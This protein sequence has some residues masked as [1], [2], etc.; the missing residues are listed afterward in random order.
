MEGVASPAP[1]PPSAQSGREGRWR[2]RRWAVG[3]ALATLVQADG[4]RAVRARP[5][6]RCTRGA[7]ERRGPVT[8]PSPWVAASMRA[9]TER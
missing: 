1:A 4:R 5:A 2:A 9:R 6:C 8:W 7:E 3:C